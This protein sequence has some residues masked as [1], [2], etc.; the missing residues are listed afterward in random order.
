[1]SIGPASTPEMLHRAVPRLTRL[2]SS[3]PWAVVDIPFGDELP[4]TRIEALG[5]ARPVNERGFSF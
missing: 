5:M 1:M 4:V 3:N 2:G